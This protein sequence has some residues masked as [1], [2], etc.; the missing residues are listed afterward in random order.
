M[1]Y[2]EI[3]CQ[4]CGVSF[5]IARNRRADEPHSAAWDY[6]GSAYSGCTVV[7]LFN[8][9]CGDGTGS[10]CKIFD[11]GRHVFQHLAG[12]GCA[13]VDAYSGYRIPVEEMQGCRAVQ[14]LAKKEEGWQ[15][16]AD[17]ENFEVESPFFLT[18]V[19]DGSPDS[20]PLQGIR[21]AR[22]GNSSIWIA[23]VSYRSIVYL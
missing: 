19:G 15:P 4:I 20:V 7:G 17:D 14:A 13:S 10:G 11:N 2:Y 1:G 8:E 5:A 23:N 9:T 6:T 21:P 3:Y 18:G 16:E 12:P 22:H